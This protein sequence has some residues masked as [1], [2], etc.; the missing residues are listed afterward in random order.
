LS[1]RHEP[2]PF[3]VK[4]EAGIADGFSGQT[5]SQIHHL[6][7]FLFFDQL[8]VVTRNQ[9]DTIELGRDNIPLSRE[10]AAVN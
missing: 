10:Y 5:K 9:L 3:L 8:S 2:F 4:N 6:P 1:L 7:E